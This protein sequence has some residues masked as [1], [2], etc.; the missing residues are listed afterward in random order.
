MRLK[1]V[2]N[3]NIGGYNISYKHP[4]KPIY[5]GSTPD[6][7]TEVIKGINP[8]MFGGGMDGQVESIK[9][10]WREY[11]VGNFLDHP[12]IVS[13]KE[14]IEGFSFEPYLVSRHA[15]YSTLKDVH[16]H[17]D[18]DIRSLLL[19]QTAKALAYMH[20]QGF[21]HRDVKPTNVAYDGLATCAVVDLGF[22]ERKGDPT[23]ASRRIM[24]GTPGYEAPEIID[25]EEPDFPQDVYGFALTMGDI[26]FGKRAM[27]FYKKIPPRLNLPIILI[28]SPW[29]SVSG[30]IHQAIQDNPDKR[31]PIDEFVET[32]SKDNEA[33]L[34]VA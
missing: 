14:M 4:D 12:N 15:G 19:L 20:E 34:D 23:F 33:A 28:S 21:V 2:S 31:P 10:L 29:R 5:W 22:T 9:N 1:K 8:P 6:G 27:Q 11:M 25:G 17:M 30:L 32:L 16:H 3:M 7:N 13:G 18:P 24:V 26:L